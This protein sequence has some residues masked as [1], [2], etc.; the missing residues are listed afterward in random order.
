M[1]VTPVLESPPRRPRRRFTAE[2]RA[3]HLAAWKRSGQSARDYGLIHGL[4]PWQLYAWQGQGKRCRL[5]SAEAASS[6]PA[7]FLAL[8][9]TPDRPT[10]SATTVTLRHGATEFVVSG[11]AD[12]SE[13]AALLRA[14]CREVLDV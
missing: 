13:V 6:A 3:G 9:L 10:T 7:R 14:I 12:P 11:T 4:E 5:S 2:Q 8:R 1:D